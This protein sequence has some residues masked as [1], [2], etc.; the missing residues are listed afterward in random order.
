MFFLRGASA[1]GYWPASER[2]GTGGIRVLGNSGG[3]YLTVGYG[4]P[5]RAMQTA[6]EHGDKDRR[7]L[8]EIIIE[9]QVQGKGHWSYRLGTNKDSE[10]GTREIG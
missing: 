1:R 7:Y 9:H 5:T 3:R 4:V 2:K 6:S 10:G 8:L